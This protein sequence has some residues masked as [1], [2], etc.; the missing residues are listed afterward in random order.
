[1]TIVA[2]EATLEIEN[3]VGSALPITALTNA[4]PGVATS[5]A[6]G[7]TNGDYVRLAVTSGMVDLDGQVCR[8]ANVDTNTFELE[9]IDTTDFGTWESGGGSAYEITAWFAFTAA[10]DIDLGNATPT[11]L[12]GSKLFHRNTVTLYGRSG[13]QSGSISVHHEPA[14]SALAKLRGLSNSTTV[15]FR[16]TWNDGSLM[17]FGAKT[18]YSGGRTANGNQIVTGTVPLTVQGAYGIVDYAS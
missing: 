2:T 4:N 9:G 13:S 5:A 17:A 11:E 14:T 1:M 7:L 10:T 15:A 12:D 16:N 3:T 6:H 8:V 18:A